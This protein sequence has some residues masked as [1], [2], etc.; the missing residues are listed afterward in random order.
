[1]V[2]VNVIPMV[3]IHHPTNMQR[4]TSDNV[5]KS[6]VATG[7]PSVHVGGICAQ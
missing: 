1:M 6:K 5:L 7:S 4:G 2:F 3:C